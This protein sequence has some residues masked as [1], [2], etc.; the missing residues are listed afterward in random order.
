M[1]VFFPDNKQ[2]LA[3]NQGPR[4]KD[5]RSR[6]LDAKRLK[7][8]SEPKHSMVFGQLVMPVQRCAEAPAAAAVA[9]DMGSD[10][11]GKSAYWKNLGSF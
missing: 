5:I 2:Q 3:T 10:Y 9:G 7:K 1:K 8:S 4:T 6:R 11:V